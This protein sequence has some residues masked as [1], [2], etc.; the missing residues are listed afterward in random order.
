MSSSD[1]LG[2]RKIKIYV[3]IYSPVNN[4]KAFYLNF[5]VGYS[6]IIARKFEL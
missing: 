1:Q 4:T 6:S 2:N 5:H 3:F